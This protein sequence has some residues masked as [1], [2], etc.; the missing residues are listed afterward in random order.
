MITILATS[1]VHVFIYVSHGH[2]CLGYGASAI[3]YSATY[4]PSNKTVAIKIIDLD[5]FE[6]HQIE[7]LRVIYSSLILIIFLA[8]DT[9]DVFE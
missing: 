4:K 1:L 7:E 3:V 2:E 6:R 9:S 8:R 5:S